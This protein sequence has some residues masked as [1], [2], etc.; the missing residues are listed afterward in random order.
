MVLEKN[1]SNKACTQRNVLFFLIRN[2][3]QNEGVKSQFTK[4][5]IMICISHSR[6]RNEPQTWI[7]MEMFCLILKEREKK[8]A[9]EREPPTPQGCRPATKLIPGFLLLSSPRGSHLVLFGI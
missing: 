8:K 9:T 2:F 7:V 4:I 6:D 3:F 1:I 5:K